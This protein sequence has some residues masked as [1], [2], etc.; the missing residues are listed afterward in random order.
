M[1]AS[2]EIARLKVQ[3]RDLQQ[4]L[5][6]AKAACRH[7]DMQKVGEGVKCNQCGEWFGWYCPKSE[8]FVCHYESRD[9]KV[10]LIDGERVDVPEGHDPKNE[11]D[12][13]CIFCGSPQER[14]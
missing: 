12:D 6:A 5:A 8:D 7:T 11:S 9:K 1:M 10:T 4:Q 13:Y 2:E 14:K 3:V